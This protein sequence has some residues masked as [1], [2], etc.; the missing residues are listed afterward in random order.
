M[1]KIV[2]LRVPDDLRR[3]ITAYADANTLNFSQAVRILVSTSLDGV[4]AR[5]ATLREAAVA[6]GIGIGLAQWRRH[7][8]QAAEDARADALA[9][10]ARFR[11]GR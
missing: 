3:R 10:P 9:G 5:D 6:E 11:Q 1:A 2:T 8:A 7:G 4:R